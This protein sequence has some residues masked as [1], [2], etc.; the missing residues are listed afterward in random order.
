MPEKQ[1]NADYYATQC[2]FQLASYPTLCAVMG[3]QSRRRLAGSVARAAQRCIE[4][5]P[6]T[7]P[8]YR[9]VM[10]MVAGDPELK[11]F[12]PAFILTIFFGWVI[13]KLLDFIWLNWTAMPNGEP[14]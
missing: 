9:T 11:G 12:I 3:V 8:D 2:E 1:F 5:D 14:D 7:K 13:Q 6:N 4:T 10:G